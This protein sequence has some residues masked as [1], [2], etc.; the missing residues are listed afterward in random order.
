MALA[1]RA[2]AR[3]AAGICALWGLLALSACEGALGTSPPH[4]APANP[5]AEAGDGEV[6]LRWGAVTDA[7]RYVILWGNDPDVPP[8]TTRSPASRTRATPTRGSRTFASTATRSS[9]RRAADAARKVSPSW[10]LRVRCRAGSS[11]PPLRRKIRDTPSI[12]R[13]RLG[14][15]TTACISRRSNRSSRPAVLMRPS[16]PRTLATDTR[17]HLHHDGHLLPRVCNERITDRRRRT[18]GRV[19]RGN[20]QRA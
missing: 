20:P 18:G 16:S 17:R 10:R 13:P 14:R 9:P 3:A 12:S 15:L 8:T 7:T 1:V 19:A 11:G 2:A 5:S 4:A 6:E